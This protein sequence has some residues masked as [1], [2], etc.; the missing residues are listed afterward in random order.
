LSVS[1][2]FSHAGDDT[3]Y[4]S[5]RSL[6]WSR[7]PTT[8]SPGPLSSAAEY[9]MLVQSLIASGVISDPGMIYFD[10]RPSSHVPTIELRVCD[11]CHSVD[12]VVLIAGLFRAAV[13][14]E[15]AVAKA[16]KP[17]TWV[18]PTLQRAAM[19]RAARSGLEDDLVD[20]RGPRSVP[21]R[22]VL[23]TMVEELA[24]EL[25]AGGDEALVREL[26]QHAL[27]RGSA[28]ARQREALRRRGRFSDVVDLILAETRGDG[29]P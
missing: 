7:W 27:A 28:A 1:S 3:G 20:L 25:A 21:A 4:A 17:P 22:V 15:L 12:T 9:Q 10:V 6:I 2:P 19:W 23:Q 29:T 8:G 5:S 24:P 13:A 16:G 11:A 18:H 14:H 26:C